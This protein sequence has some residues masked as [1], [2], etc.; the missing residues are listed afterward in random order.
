MSEFEIGL[1]YQ[2]IWDQKIR[3]VLFCNDR[4]STV[5]EQTKLSKAQN[6][7]PEQSSIGSNQHL[8]TGI[9]L[10]REKNPSKLLKILK[11]HTPMSNDKVTH[12]LNWVV[13]MVLGWFIFT[14]LLLYVIA[15]GWLVGGQWFN[16]QAVVTEQD[17]LCWIHLQTWRPSM[18]SL[19]NELW[20][21]WDLSL[22]V[23]WRGRDG[24]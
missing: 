5:A 15:I 10:L 17:C 7:K 12:S 14:F 9:T 1:P 8:P 16:L 2:N 11:V 24:P 21:V 13:H 23:V 18:A 20:M 22:A 4:T 6:D 3:I 19:F